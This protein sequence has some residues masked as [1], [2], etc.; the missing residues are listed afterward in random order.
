MSSH[1]QC[2]FL[3]PRD[4]ICPANSE[5]RAPSQLRANHSRSPQVLLAA[6]LLHFADCHLPEPHSLLL[7]FAC[8]ASAE[9]SA[10]VAAACSAELPPDSSPAARPAI[11]PAVPKLPADTNSAPKFQR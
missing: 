11:A 7:R 2:T 5:F 4:S 8:W 1:P 9:L 10:A 6:N 3:N